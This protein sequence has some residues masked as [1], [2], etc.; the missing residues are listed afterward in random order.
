MNTVRIEQP[1]PRQAVIENELRWHEEEAH[2][3]QHI[4]GI[5]YI[6]PAFDDIVA[7][8]VAYLDLTPGQ[9]VL[10]MGS[11]PGKETLIFSRRGQTVYTFDLSYVQLAAAREQVLR[12]NPDAQVFWVQ[13]NAEELPF[14]TDAFGAVYGK[15]ILHHLDLDIA[16]D[17]VGRVLTAGGRATFAEP[18][19]WHPLIWLG[20]RLTPQLRTRDEHPLQWQELAAFAVRFDARPVEHFYVAAPLAF[21]L[22][23]IPGGERAFRRVWQILNAVD[24]RLFARL[25]LVRDLAW[26]GVVFLRK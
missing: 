15:A 13:A 12:N 3:R 5:L 14:A 17:E 7:A 9:R 1:A 26:Y 25:P 4:D 22:R 19:A 21:T 23:F 10:E 24:H 8:Q 2:R 18:M 20:R 16:A 6:S 11:G